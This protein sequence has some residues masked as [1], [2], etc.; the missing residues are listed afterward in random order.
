MDCEPPSTLAEPTLP[1]DDDIVGVWRW[2][3]F[4]VVA[5][6]AVAVPSLWAAVPSQHVPAWIRGAAT[7]AYL[8]GL[9]GGALFAWIWPERRHRVFRYAVLDAGLVIR[10]GWLWQTVEVVPFTRVQSVDTSTGPLLRSAGLARVH[11]HTAAA[12]ASPVIPGLDVDSARRLV[13]EIT[14]RAGADDAA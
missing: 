6:A 5:V 3:A 14:A 9:A 13:A 10:R 1:L 2:H 12:G 4:G 8:T 7:A 11:V